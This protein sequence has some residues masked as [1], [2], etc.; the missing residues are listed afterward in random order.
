[1]WIAPLNKMSDAD[2]KVVYLHWGN[3]YHLNENDFQQQLSQK[4]CNAGVDIIIG[5]H[6]HVIQPV[7]T[8]K[9]SDNNHETIVAY[10]LGN[11]LSNQRREDFSMYDEDGLIINIDISKNHKD[12]KTTITK[13][14][15]IPTWLNKYYNNQTSKYIF[16][17]IPLDKTFDL[18]KASHL[19]KN[20]AKKSYE[21]TSSQIKTS[22]L[23]SI[24]KN[25]FK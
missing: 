6:P 16:E 24:S 21:H 22:D 11:F 25:P 13:V 2:L 19:D 7:T 4:L 18:N 3:K 20:K 10:S 23:I 17:I 12:N 15:C 5:S 8:I 14:C 1:M 9:S